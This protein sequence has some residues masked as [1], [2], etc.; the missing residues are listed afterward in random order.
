MNGSRRVTGFESW[1][2]GLPPMYFGMTWKPRLTARKVMFATREVSTAM[3]I[4]ELP[5]PSTST[6]LSS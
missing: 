1:S 4:A 3:S 5:N 6:F 2:S